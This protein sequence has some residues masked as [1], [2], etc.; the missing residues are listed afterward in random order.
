MK[1]S[2]VI[3]CRNAA[4]TLA[5]TLRSVL[6]QTHPAEEILVVDDGSADASRA[7]A[8]SFGPPVRLLAQ[9]RL[10]ASAAR[11]AGAQHATGDALMFLDADDL[12]APNVLHELSAT[13]AEKPGGIACCAWR[14][15]V[16][17]EQVWLSRPA[18]CRR[19]GAFEDR[20]SAWLQGWY[21][22]P[23]SV[24]WSRSAYLRSGGWDPS[25]RI[26]QDGELMLRALL[27][28]APLAF[29]ER[30]IAYYRRPGAGRTSLSAGPVDRAKIEGR[31]EVLHRW[32]G[33]AEALWPACRQALAAAFDRLRQEAMGFPDLARAC[34]VQAGLLGGPRPW[35]RFRADL[36]G[37]DVAAGRVIRRLESWATPASK[38]LQ[39]VSQ[40]GGA[41]AAHCPQP[42]VSVVIPSFNRAETLGRAIDSVLRQTYERFELIVIDDGSTD[43]TEA[44]LAREADPRLR[45]ERQRQNGGVARA[46]NRGVAL[47]RGEYI[48]FLDSDDAWAPRKLEAQLRVFAEASSSLGVVYGG[49]E[50]WGKA[51]RRS[52]DRPCARGYVYPELLRRNVLFGGASN[53]LLRREVFE[54][55]GGFDPS[56]PANE[57]HEFW[58][59]VSQHFLVDYVDAPLSRYFDERGEHASTGQ[60]RSRNLEA[61]LEAR[62]LLH[63]RYRQDMRLAG[64]E[65]GF[66]LA[67]AQR[68]S[69]APTA[70]SGAALRL[71][72]EAVLANPLH[73][74][75][76]LWLALAALPRSGRGAVRATWRTIRDLCFLPR[77]SGP[78]E[79]LR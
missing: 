52:V 2:V 42:L 3:P 12:L 53:A 74:E 55:V 61:H 73:G 21:Q 65:H 19:R 15:W 48:A 62:A 5:Q 1:I 71:A 24:L 75:S 37:V 20:V 31:F 54:V 56:F 72:G 28:G 30:A 63:A 60:R 68:C 33:R 79:Q 16:E 23:C 43:H 9:G 26:N 27:V 41:R 49:V 18:S 59:R 69:A 11:R 13:L 40:R 35:R 58:L 64:V 77:P 34:E 8:E 17:H 76:Y 70:R 67:S 66:L 51:G 25:V 50:V 78:L 29:T 39:G 36:R 47:A 14:R 38:R 46:R 32:A 57:D 10:G 45:Y 22:P 6:R 44:L 4:A 7:I